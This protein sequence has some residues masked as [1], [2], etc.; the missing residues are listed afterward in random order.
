M[1]YI[2][3]NKICSLSAFSNDVC[4]AL[5]QKLRKC[6]RL[7]KGRCSTRRGLVKSGLLNLP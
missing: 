2:S 4:F 6:E 7:K 5:F 3:A 1:D